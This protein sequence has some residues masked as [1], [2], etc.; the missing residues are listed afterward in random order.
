MTTTGGE[1]TTLLQDDPEFFEELSEYLDVLSNPTR[2]RILKAIERRPKDVR[3]IAGDIRTSYENTK[4]HLDKL[5]RTGV[6]K[7]E[8]GLGQ[9]T[10][11]GVHPVWKYSLIPGGME[12]IIR[13]LGLFSNINMTLADAELNA[14]IARVKG[15]MAEERA[16]TT[17]VLIVV[18]GPDDG[19][20]FP[21]QEEVTAIGRR[22]AAA[23][24]APGEII[25]SDYYSA[26]TR[27][28]RPHARITRSKG[29]YV[30]EDCGS[31]GG[32]LL[33]A[34]PIT[35]HSPVPLSDG[36]LIDLGKGVKG[37]R[38]IVALPGREG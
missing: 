9:E 11:R 36:D 37:V 2:L 8:A 4:K 19:A 26:V 6:V 23:E 15:M 14:R 16:G 27:V 22:D 35:A 29:G 34:E 13:N 24:P 30:I 21:V 33:N 28:S 25:F 17:P 1:Q 18:G 32:T 10:A 7:K 12:A 31:T 20:A 3:E 5:L 38:L